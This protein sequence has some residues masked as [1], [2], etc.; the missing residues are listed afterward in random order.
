MSENKEQSMNKLRLKVGIFAIVS[1][2][3]IGVV[4]VFVNDQPY[5]WR[6]CH[7]VYV[8]VD[9]A[10]GLKYKSPVR[11]LGIDIGYLKSVELFQTNV[12]LGICIT[13]PV[14]VLPSTRAYIRGEGF[15]GDKFVEL[16]PVESLIDENGDDR[17][18]SQIPVSF[19]RGVHPFKFLSFI[20]VISRSLA[21]PQ[22]G[23]E[24]PVGSEAK[25][26]QEVM[27]RVS[28]MVEEMTKVT[29]NLSDVLDPEE[30]KDTIQSLNQA[31]KNVSKTLS[32]KGS[33]TG[34]AQRTLAKLEDAIEQLRDQ[35]TR[36]NQG[37]GSVGKLLN[38]PKY[39]DL[40]EETL[41]NVN[42]FLG[43][44]AGVR[45][46]VQMSVDQIPAYNGTRGN[47]LVQIWP[48]KNRYYLIGAG[49]DP[50]GL[51]TQT[52]TTTTVSG[53][54]PVTVST[55]QL[56]KRGL[57]I[58]ALLGVVLWD[59]LDLGAGLLYGDGAIHVGANL[60]P[61]DN[62]EMFQLQSQ[63]Y[64]R[65]PGTLSPDPLLHTRFRVIAQP[66]PVVYF[67]AGIESYRKINGKFPWLM[68]G[69]VRFDDE[70]IKT[71][72]SFL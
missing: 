47:F 45:I 3:L 24:I 59:R 8:K 7:L 53:Q 44:A 9:D 21:A 64:Y 52:E 60:G 50:V 65:A 26:M 35:M 11:S 63:L 71:L 18:P 4:S 36:I 34:T 67:S 70:D 6:A 55:V 32:P 66:F 14:E 33:L 30:I 27:N 1:F 48:R 29:K 39:A 28:D 72:F 19:F 22:N 49:V 54:S 10:T 56:E 37:K 62:V 61:S 17:K 16:K 51:F 58:T 42:A 69:G 12:R 43:K 31:L 2:V 20:N 46:V 15:L 41:K 57:V 38:D 5:W 68:G 23:N 13:A 25:D 40:M